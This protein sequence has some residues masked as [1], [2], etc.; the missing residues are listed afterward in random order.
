M[1]N[2]VAFR[3][4]VVSKHVFVPQVYAYS[5]TS[6][7]D[8]S[9]IAEEYIEGIPLST[10]W[11]TFNSSQ[12][13]SITHKVASIVVDLAEIRFPKIGGLV[14]ETFDPAPTV[15][16]SKL[17]K[18]R[19]KFHKK[20]YYH[21]GPYESTKEYMLASYDKEIYYYSN[22][23]EDDIDESL[24]EDISVA[25]FV[26]HLRE[27]R[28]V[29]EKMDIKDEPFVLVHGDL[30]GRNILMSGDQVA[31][32][33]DW[34]FAGSYPL[35]EV[36]SDGEIDVV[37]ADSKEL[38]EENEIWGGKIREYVEELVEKRGWEKGDVEVL[39]GEGNRG[40]AVVRGEMVP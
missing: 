24:F 38:E 15:E 19:G 34:E 11:T 7:P 4:F 2:E 33:L 39:L 21:I 18:G 20:D 25:N 16:G 36:L 27:K 40:L 32:V 6:D 23:D 3:R 5:A 17:F 10:V 35:S 28:A 30:H 13:D 29:T 14:P 37:E 8:T 22:A 1:S 12:K 26:E 31:A 9:Y